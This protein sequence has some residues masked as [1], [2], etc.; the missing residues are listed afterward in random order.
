LGAAVRINAGH[1][2]HFS[3]PAVQSKSLGQFLLGE[4][5]RLRLGDQIK[6]SKVILLNPA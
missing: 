3:L 6:A 1:G 5:N 4:N 2:R